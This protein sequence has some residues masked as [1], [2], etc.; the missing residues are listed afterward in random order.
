[1]STLI[2][3]SQ[4]NIKEARQTVYGNLVLGS[5]SKEYLRTLDS[6]RQA[7][8]VFVNQKGKPYFKMG[9]DNFGITSVTVLFPVAVINA[10]SIVTEIKFYVYPFN[11]TPYDGL[12]LDADTKY[13]LDKSRW[14]DAITATNLESSFQ[15]DNVSAKNFSR[16]ET[17]V[18]LQQ[19]PSTALTDKIIKLISDKYGTGEVKSMGKEY[20]KQ[21][22]YL[23]ET[24][25]KTQYM[26]IAFAKVAPATGL[27]EPKLVF[28]V[29]SYKYNEAARKK[30]GLNKEANVLKP[31]F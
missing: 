31:N 4:P 27:L 25:W 14:D 28:H 30:Y 26:D 19:E 15:F 12:Q 5:N 11:T 10:E 29:L 18:V 22:D 17:P 9:Q 13:R 3:C 16:Y 21:S 20:S 2:S 7:G 1:M 6:L 23:K 24:T 8:V